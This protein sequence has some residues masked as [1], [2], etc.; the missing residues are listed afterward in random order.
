L[1]A[2]GNGLAHWAQTLPS[3]SEGLAA[4][5]ATVIPTGAVRHEPR[6][7][8]ICSKNAGSRQCR[9]AS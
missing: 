2:P 1:P 5:A 7:G 6:S 4:G 9:C 3:S 8:G